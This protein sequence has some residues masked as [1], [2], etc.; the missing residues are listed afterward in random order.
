MLNIVVDNIKRQEINNIVLGVYAPLK[1]F[2]REK[3]LNGVL[4][5]MKLND[6]TLW[7]IPIVFDIFSEDVARINGVNE[8]TLSDEKGKLLVR[9]LEPEIYKLDKKDFAQKI[10]GTLDKEH[11]GV[12]QVFE[13]KDH[14]L[15]GE[16]ELIRDDEFSNDYSP[17]Y[18]SQL[19]KNNGWKTI[20][21]FQTRN[22]PHLSHEYLQK[23]ALEN[24]DALFIQPVIGKK[25]SGDFKDEV[26]IDTYK[27]LLDKHYPKDRVHFDVLPL[28]MRY[29]GPREA[30]FHALIRKN[31]GCTHMIIGRDHAG[32]GN[33]YGPYD[34]H[35][36]FDN[37]TQDEV[38]IKILKF[39][40]AFHCND[41][42]GLVTAD[43]CSHPK[44]SRVFLSGTQIREM[45]K[46]GEE[47]P[48]EFMRKE[49]SKYLLN[50]PNPFI[51]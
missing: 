19:F 38:G 1:G 18:T 3:D 45:I 35:K 24:V 14:L 27:L 42:N 47:L 5:D 20:V 34:A 4:N 12:R 49:V 6:G 37:F 44:E 33:Y 10:F 30:L 40:N 26:I 9:I 25:K 41:C 28:A 31:Y 43:K 11:P 17:K 22:A 46:N 16:I 36:I 15:G 13:M 48:K 50:H 7:P 32:V 8:I 39:D 29:A 2:L 21:A 23:L 51:D